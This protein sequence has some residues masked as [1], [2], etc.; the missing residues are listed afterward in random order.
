MGGRSRRIQFGRRANLAAERLLIFAFEGVVGDYFQPSMWRTD[1]HALYLRTKAIAC[2]R[3]ISARY[4]LALFFVCDVDRATYI[5]Q[6]LIQRG[7]NIDGAYMSTHSPW[8]RLPLC[9]D[10]VYADFAIAEPLSDRVLVF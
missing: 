2:L 6:Y 9:Y 5:V 10:Q 1:C 3:S 4:Q 8:S 7:V